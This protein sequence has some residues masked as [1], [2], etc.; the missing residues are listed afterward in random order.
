MVKSIAEEAG[1]EMPSFL[2]YVGRYTLPVLLPI[3]V[4]ATWIFF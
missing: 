2:G 3:F 1:V 4:L